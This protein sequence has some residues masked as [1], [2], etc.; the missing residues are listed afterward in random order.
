MLSFMR[1]KPRPTGRTIIQEHML[2]VARHQG[3]P[4]ITRP[5]VRRAPSLTPQQIEALV[6]GVII[7][8]SVGYVFG[9]HL[10]KALVT[11]AFRVY[12]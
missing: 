8:G 10:V 3:L 2:A 7:L 6:A 11:G 4:T 5:R 9:Y 1:P 12:H